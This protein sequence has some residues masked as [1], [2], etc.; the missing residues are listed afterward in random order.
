MCGSSPLIDPAS[1][2][3]T[4]PSRG[5]EEERLS[6]TLELGDFG[7]SAENACADGVVKNLSFT[8]VGNYANVGFVLAIW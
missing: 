1:G 5:E 2:V 7:G 3:P 4:S 8:L 6:P